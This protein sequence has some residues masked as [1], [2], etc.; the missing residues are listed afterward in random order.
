MYERTMALKNQ[1]PSLKIMIA[2][3]GWNAGSGPFS[4]MVSN[5]G[6]RRNFVNNA[7]KFLK[8]NK[9]DGLGNI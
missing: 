1:N 6:V 9:F 5:P 8:D 3:G 7:V 4:T 2:V